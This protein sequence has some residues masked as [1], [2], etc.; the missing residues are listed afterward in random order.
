MM[1]LT[2]HKEKYEEPSG[3][4]QFLR[5]S[6][7]NARIK[8]IVQFGSERI[9][10]FMLEK[11]EGS[12]KLVTE[13]FNKGNILLLDSKYVVLAA[14]EYPRVKDRTIRP[15][16]AYTYPKREFDVFEIKKSELKK[17]LTSS[18][19]DKL[20]TCIATELGVGGLYAEEICAGADKN[21]VPKELD[22]EEISRVYRNL[23]N[24]FNKSLTPRLFLDR[25]QKL[26]DFTP[27]TLRIYEHTEH[28]VYSFKDYSSLLEEM[29]LKGL[30]E[31]KKPSKEKAEKEKFEK[32]IAMQQKAILN[33]EKEETDIKDKAELI[34]NNYQ[35]VSDILKQVNDAVK[36]IGFG[37]VEKKL[38]GHKIVKAIDGKEKTITVNI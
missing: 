11:K 15:K 12:F 23:T 10:C 32:R 4:C 22:D 18:I 6:I 14:A 5:K 1:Y 20:V 24:L 2:D 16:I 21:K 27:V 38:K 25:E 34:Y 30:L 28:E 7:S 17:T 29:H 9:A 35:M 26:I 31:E 33:L 36:K 19:K 3:F 37:E 13:F 8:D